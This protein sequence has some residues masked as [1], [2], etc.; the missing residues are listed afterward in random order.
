M[1]TLQRTR[2]RLVLAAVL[3]ATVAACTHTA[4]PWGAPGE[5]I[6]VPPSPT[7][8]IG[9]EWILVE[10]GNQG[11]LDY[12]VATLV[13]PEP[14]KIAGS[15]SCNRFSGTVMIS[16]ESMDIG[17]LSTTRRAC[18]AGVMAQEIRYLQA[19]E[20]ADRIVEEGTTYL[21]IFTPASEYPLRFTRKP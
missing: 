15:G 9:S 3:T 11:V 18:P 6:L 2:G 13:F 8:L 5:E 12:A 7:S 16:G 20:D 21:L 10:L 17:P 4:Y 1:G 19:L 14:G